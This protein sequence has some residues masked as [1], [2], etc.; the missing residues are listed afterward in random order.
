L[1][2]LQNSL[3]D[4]ETVLS[5]APDMHCQHCQRD[6]TI[7]ICDDA[8]ARL[9]N[10]AKCPNL[11]P[12]WIARIQAQRFLGRFQIAAD[13]ERAKAETQKIEPPKP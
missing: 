13:R 6:M 8:D 2:L 1:Q 10:L 9:E 4:H 5:Q 12:A 3:F 11:D 7:C